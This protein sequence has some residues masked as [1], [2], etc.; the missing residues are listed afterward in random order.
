MVPTKASS[1]TSLEWMSADDS[2]SDLDYNGWKPERRS[3]SNCSI[4]SSAAFQ[5]L[6]Q[7]QRSS[8]CSPD[9]ISLKSESPAFQ[10]RRAALSRRSTS[11]LSSYLPLLGTAPSLAY[12]PTA[13]SSSLVS[14][15]DFA[16]YSSGTSDFTI[17]P[18][19]PRH[20]P[21]FSTSACGTRD[22]E[23]VIPFVGDIACTH[24]L[25]EAN[26]QKCAT[27]GPEVVGID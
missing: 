27:G 19:P 8:S 12:S 15:A 14:L 23:L 4:S 1:T 18:L 9:G 2:K 7:F 26:L 24:P 5:Y 10:P 13:S 11:N 20:N 16:T 25:T 21:S 3:R 22:L 6:S 17:R